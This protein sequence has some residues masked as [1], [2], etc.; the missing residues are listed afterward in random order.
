MILLDNNLSPI[1]YCVV[2][3]VPSSLEHR[4]L[5][6]T[7]DGFKEADVAVRVALA[8][9]R[10]SSGW[11]QCAQGNWMQLRKGKSDES[12]AGGRLVICTLHVFNVLMLNI[13]QDLQRIPS[14]IIASCC[15]RSNWG[16]STGVNSTGDNDTSV[17]SIGVTGTSVNTGSKYLPCFIF[18]IFYL[19]HIIKLD[20]YDRE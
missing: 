5:L 4:M 17:N 19:S 15:T 18:I 8:Y 6:Y 2:K 16:T 10:L 13:I 12:W 20:V 1:L 7:C 9:G 11:R 14:S 3:V